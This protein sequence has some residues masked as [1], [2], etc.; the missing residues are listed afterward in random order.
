MTAY[1]TSYTTSVR[2]T[3]DARK[4]FLLLQDNLSRIKVSNP[5]LKLEVELVKGLKE[6]FLK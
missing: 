6:T 4:K 1:M 2:K 5:G 3:P